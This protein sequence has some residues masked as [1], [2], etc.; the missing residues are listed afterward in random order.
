MAIGLAKMLGFELNENFNYPY[1]SKSVTEF[2][3]RWHISLGNWF[4]EYVYIPLGGNRRGLPRQIFNLFIVWFLTGLWHGAGWNFILWGLYFFVLLLAEKLFLLQLLKKLPKFVGNIYTFLA[5]LFSWAIFANDDLV[6]LKG[7]TAA[8]FGANGAYSADFA[9]YLKSYAVILLFGAVFSTDY[10]RKLFRKLIKAQYVKIIIAF[11]FIAL[12][13]IMLIGD[14]FN[15]F[16]Y[17]R[18]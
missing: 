8:L 18:F 15:P 5:V 17:F 11:A 9:Y 6:K 7:F 16:L 14:S 12:S 4:R 13:V 3:R 10:P 1:M 2:W